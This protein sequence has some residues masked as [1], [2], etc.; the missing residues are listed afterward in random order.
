MNA[1]IYTRVSTREQAIDGMSLITQAKQCHAYAAH[2]DYK[3][4]ELFKEEGQSAKTINRPVLQSMLRFC[5]TQK[6]K[7]DAV[8]IARIDRLARHQMDYGKLRA[9]LGSYGIRVISVAEQFDDDPVGRFMES[10][11]A[12]LAQLDNEIR[13]E[14]S[15]N[16]MIEGVESGRWM[17]KPP[18]GYRTAI[19]NGKKN[20]APISEDLSSLIREA[21]VLIDAGVPPAEAHRRLVAK[22]LASDGEPI[23]IQSFSKMLYKKIYKGV[24]VGF[25]KEVVSDSIQPIVEP[26]LWDRVYARL[27]RKNTKPTRYHKLSPD[28]PLRGLLYCDHGHRMT[29]S[30]PRG[31]GGYY[32]KYHCPKCRGRKTSF[33]TAMVEEQFVAYLN[34]LSYDERIREALTT[35]IDLTIEQRQKNS[36]ENLRSLE[37]KLK[38]LDEQEFQI[39]QKNLKGVYNDELTA[40]LL[41][42][43]GDEH[44]EVAGQIGEIQLAN[45]A[46]E[47]AVRFGFEILTHVGSTWESIEDLSVKDRFQKWLF[48]AGLVFDGE[49]FGTSQKPLCLSIKK[50]FSEEKSLLVIP[51][52]IEPLLPG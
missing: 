2:N 19:V 41:K 8:I 14:R 46:P 22:G 26:E 7:I 12:G 39:T 44:A 37:K 48:P 16:G 43:N 17:W 31:N 49:K 21:W 47:K 52:G 33:D 5:A 6:G 35:A 4:I 42:K 9:M 27:T 28:F 34:E 30:S 38:A 36:K 40:R 3:V 20:I 1:V 50:D 25:G 32:P 11:L 10:T 29:G 18:F 23:A 24:V 45:Y 51:R 13:A 15:K